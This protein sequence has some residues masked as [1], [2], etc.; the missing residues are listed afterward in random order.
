MAK[1]NQESSSVKKLVEAAIYN[2]DQNRESVGDLES[3]FQKVCYELMIN[4]FT[5]E[6]ETTLNLHQ[7]TLTTLLDGVRTVR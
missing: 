3:V 6:L 4:I 7:S 5:P 2:F 1:V